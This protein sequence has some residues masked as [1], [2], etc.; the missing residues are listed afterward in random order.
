M[1]DWLIDLE[2]LKLYPAYRRL[3][4]G[5]TL[6]AI[7]S[8]LTVFTVILQVFSMTNSSFSVGVIGLFTGI[9]SIFLAL[10]GGILG[11]KFDRRKI[12]LISTFLQL[13]G[14]MFLWLYAL[15]G[16]TNIFFPY[17]MIGWIFLLGALNVPVGKAILP[18]LI[19][20]EHLQSAITL[21]VFSIHSAMVTGPL[22]G[23]FLVMKYGIATLYFIDMCSFC[24]ALYG[25]V[26]LPPMGSMQGLDQKSWYSLKEGIK[27]V[28]RAPIILGAIY[29]D[30]ALAFFGMP[31]ALFSAINISRLQGNEAQLG[32]ILSAPSLGGLLAMLLS[33]CLKHFKSPGVVMVVFC[34][35]CALI[36][37]GF[38][39]S[40]SIIVSLCLLFFMG[41]FDSF[42]VA[43]RNTVIQKVTPD[44]YRARVSALEYIFDNSSTQLG[45]FRAGLIAL[46]VAPHFAAL[47]GGFSTLI[48]ASLTFLLFPALIQMRRHFSSTNR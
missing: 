33:G 42:L 24:V 48:L 45:N 34:G 35:L 9:P 15:L 2:S 46:V 6:S 32:L 8:H 36:I 13:I 25:I 43:I 38:S 40:T 10:W 21:R 23:G 39:L 44:A 31:N 27:F 5:S 17:C 16:G 26:R 4:I 37:I 47:I 1:R 30:F 18:H 20:E 28:K 14:C 41:A 3:W 12:V 11:D 29:V 19:D 22:L 7:G